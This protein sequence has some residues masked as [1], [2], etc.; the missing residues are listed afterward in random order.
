MEGPGLGLV[1]EPEEFPFGLRCMDCDRQIST[2]ALYSERLSGVS[3][4]SFVV[5]LVCV[6]CD[7]GTP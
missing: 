1:V 4:E 2:G 3:G 6:E 5:E 7:L